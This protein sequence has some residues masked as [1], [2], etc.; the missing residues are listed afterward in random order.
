[1]RHLHPGPPRLLARAGVH[2]AVALPVDGDRR[3]IL[4]PDDVDDYCLFDPRRALTH[5]VP[6][7]PLH[8][9]ALQRLLNT[10]RPLKTCRPPS[11]GR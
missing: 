11:N 8:P 9:I 6:P 3:T 2:T 4:S 1:M 10:C 7:T 5:G